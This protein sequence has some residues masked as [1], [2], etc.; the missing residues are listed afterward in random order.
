M[1]RVIFLRIV[2]LMA[3]AMR[4]CTGMAESTWRMSA[5]HSP[6][7]RSVA[8]QVASFREI[9]STSGIKDEEGVWRTD[10]RRHRYTKGKLVT[11]HASVELI[12]GAS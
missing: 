10:S 11:S 4:M 5:R 7:V 2:G 6:Q 12:N 9:L 8:F 3:M 1:I